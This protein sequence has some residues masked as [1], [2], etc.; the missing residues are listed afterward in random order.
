ATVEQRFDPSLPEVLCHAGEMNQVFLNLIVNAVHAIEGSG[1]PLPGLIVIE[2]ACDADCAKIRISD[3]GT[4]IPEAIRDKIFDLFFTTKE[5]GK[6][7][8]Q[9]LA[10]CRD[11]VVAKHNGRIDVE[12]EVGVGTTF[13]IR[14][15]I[16]G[17]AEGKNAG[18]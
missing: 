17:M 12:S 1:K 15:P 9:G 3:N 18:D 6:G 5:V 14:L 4:G 16:D 13:T 11:V 8:G 7:T 10:I 2:T